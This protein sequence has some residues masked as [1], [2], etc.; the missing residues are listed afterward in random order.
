MS[1]FT[2]FCIT[3][4][5]NSWKNLPLA[6]ELLGLTCEKCI[7][8]LRRSLKFAWYNSNFTTFKSCCNSDNCVV[9]VSLALVY[10]IC[11]VAIVCSSFNVNFSTRIN[12]VLNNVFTN[13]LSNFINVGPLDF[14][15]SI[16][17]IIVNSL[18][19]SIRN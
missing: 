12:S 18:C 6:S 8:D 13:I 19:S 5:L 7:S 14:C 2:L 17:L 11:Y 9:C 15:L 3:V 10:D 16:F 4:S 1:M